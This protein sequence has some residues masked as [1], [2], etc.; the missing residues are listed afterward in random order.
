MLFRSVPAGQGVHRRLV[1]VELEPG[2]N[3]DEVRS[4]I[5]DDPYFR[6]DETRVAQVPRVKDLIDVGHGVRIERKGVSGRTHNQMFSY[7]MRINN[8]A[9]TAQ[10]MVAAARAAV[11]QQPGAYTMLEVPPIDFLPGDRDEL[12]RR[13]V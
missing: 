2:A 9:L 7:E 11:R 5:L 6:Y 1:Y 8:P 3:F 4:R 12:L 10:V 13:L